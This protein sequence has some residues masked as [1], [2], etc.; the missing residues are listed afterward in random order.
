VTLDPETRRP[1]DRGP[2]LGGLLDRSARRRP[3]HVAVE[4]PGAGEISY[5]ELAALADRVRDHLVRLGVR[6]GD[7]VGVCLRKSIDAVAAIF[8][9]LKAGAA[10]VPV[11]PS[12]PAWRSAY[13]LGD[14]AV[15]VAFVEAAG[16]AALSAEIAKLGPVPTLVPLESVGGGSGLRRVL[17]EADV[18]GPDATVEPTSGPAYLLYTSGSTGRPKGVV[19]THRNATSFLDWCTEALDP[20]ESDRFSSH[21]PFH[22][23]LS[24]LDLFL[25]I[26]HGATIVLIGAEQ[27]KE[28]M[29]LAALVADRRIT[30]WY[31]TP[32]ILTLLTHY[33][34]LERHD[35]GALRTVLFAGEVFPIKHLRSLMGRIPH[36]RYFNLYGPTETNVCTWYP[37]PGAIPAERTAAL[38]I[39]RVCSHLRGRIVG[40]GGADVPRGEE[41]ELCIAGPGVMRGYWN[42]PERNAAAFLVDPDGTAWYRTGDVVVE[43]AD[44]NLAFLGRRDRMVKRRGYRIELGEIED[45][46][47]RFPEAREAA[48]I[49]RSDEESGVR[50]TAFLTL[51]NGRPPTFIEIKRFCAE[52]MPAYMVPDG[53]AYPESIPK[54]STD[55]V[56]YQRLAE[57]A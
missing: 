6:P 56:D 18:N 41:G 14:C 27:G 11:D 43:E 12:A 23:D 53:F 28:P 10:Y 33:G 8:G 13:I 44:G 29:G 19:L 54:T 5:R 45:A 48:V 7:R 47:H 38:P 4:E 46:L 17:S 35:Y 31:S 55:K 57:M 52:V 49:A 50:I 40:P 24:V 21:A 26:M 51:A 25:P 39:G 42:L 15:R 20:R 22:F 3:N 16:V 37:V 36:A 34:K 2:A 32:S 1:S 9:V 30:V